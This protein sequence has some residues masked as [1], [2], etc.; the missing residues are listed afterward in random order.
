M[1]ETQ[2]EESF[3]FCSVLLEL[4]CRLKLDKIGALK[5]LFNKMAMNINASLLSMNG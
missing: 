2:T 4:V 3:L 5:C 1:L